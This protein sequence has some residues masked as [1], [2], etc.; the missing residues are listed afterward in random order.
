M[1]TIYTIEVG[2]EIIEFEGPD[3][4]SESQI[5][6]LADKHLKTAKPGQKF[7]NAVYGGERVAEP[8]IAE[9]ESSSMGAFLRGLP[10]EALF[11][12]DDEIASFAN[13]AG[14]APLDNLTGAGGGDQQAFWDNPDGFWAAV[15]NNM[16]D[17]KDQRKTDETQHPIAA[18]TGNITG[19]LSTLPRAGMAVASKL[20]QAVRSFATANPIKT[21]AVAG[22]TGGAASGAGAGEEGTRAQSAALGAGTG[23]VLGT[24]LA[25]AIELAPAVATYAKI[26]MNKA[27][28][29]EAIAQIVKA[30]QRDGFDVTSPQ[31]VQALQ[32]ELAQYTGKPVSLADVGGATRSRTGVALRSPS[33]AQQE[34]IDR[35]MARQEGSGQR[36]ARDVRENVAPRTDVHALNDDLVAQRAQEAEAL[37]RRAL[38]EEVPAEAPPPRAAVEQQFAPDEGLQRALGQE[39][40]EQF[41]RV[42]VPVE[43]APPTTTL[44]SRIVEDPE[45]QGL[46]RLPDSQKAL[47]AA[48]QRA[49][50]ERDLLAAQG[51]DISHL[52]D[53]TR[54]S[55]LDV[56]TLDYLK[57]FLDDEVN[58]LYKR[59][60]TATFKAGQAAQVKAL[61]DAIRE[62]MRAAVP[63]Y[64]D[65]LDAY[66]GSSE[67]ID[68]L[69][70]G[71]NFAR[72]APEEIAAG[73]EAR[74]TAGQELYRVG[75][76]RNLLDVLQSTKDGRSPASRILNSDEART[77]L[78]ATGVNPFNAGA[79]NKSVQQ[80]RVLDLLPRELAGSQTAQRAIAQA[81]AD[82]GADMA[83]PFNPGSPYGWAGAAIRGVINRT[84]VN[85]N[86]S[87]NA[88]LLP[89]LVETDPA[90]VQRIIT[91][92]E[93]QGN[94]AA[95]RELRRRTRE[96]QASGVGSVMIG[97]P[98]A[99][100]GVDY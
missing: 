20:P 62:R 75:A 98:V 11:N 60:D 97:A 91:E 82:A 2:D 28:E 39:P 92:L 31:G 44:K 65:Y 35:V 5:E 59:G 56:R 36:L 37:R 25:G 6:E 45:L 53:L 96:I 8:A 77:Q 19:A 51:K 73:Q 100:P 54:G 18:A 41:A 14:L 87:V 90:A 99:L 12:F 63:E 13:A 67:M 85:R 22:A 49:Q 7:P 23:L 88:E 84:S 68:A 34:A 43:G 93:D 70:E 40:P 69:E 89:R 21:A 32:S 52:P 58:T 86:A 83:L 38:F 42:P 46:V 4:L 24:G 48:L 3:N 10:H 72:L 55:D 66:K 30:L 74:S 1:S 64:G 95:A 9:D 79:L 94:M 76:A 33:Q 81:D 29:K 17:L 61:R 57:R 16:G 80:E 26:F 15:R 78:S 50:S 71:Q 27:S 47:T